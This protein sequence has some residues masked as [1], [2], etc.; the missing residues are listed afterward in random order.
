[1]AHDKYLL[2][3]GLGELSAIADIQ[4]RRPRSGACGHDVSAPSK[5]PSET[6]SGTEL[7]DKFGRS[8]HMPRTVCGCGVA[9]LPMSGHWWMS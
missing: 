4:H 3:T 7:S 2:R 5:L 9:T 1:M 6:K 8:T